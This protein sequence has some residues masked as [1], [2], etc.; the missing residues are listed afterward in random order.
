MKNNN[1]ENKTTVHSTYRCQHHIVFA[2]EFRKQ[3]I[4]GKKKR[5]I[6][7]ISRTMLIAM[8]INESTDSFQWNFVGAH[9]I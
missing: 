6:G 5:D 7:E 4:Y 1:N 2:P 9:T 3:E 8:H